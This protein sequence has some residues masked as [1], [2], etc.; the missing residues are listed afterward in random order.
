MGHLQVVAW[1][2]KTLGVRAN[3]VA[4]NGGAAASGSMELMLWLDERG[5]EWTESAVQNAAHGGSAA[6][7]EWLKARG[8]PMPVSVMAE[9]VDAM[10]AFV[11][12]SDWRGA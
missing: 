7:L 10:V 5:V 6:V 1:M 9:E 2:A 12:L 8:C 4:K 11:V 3:W